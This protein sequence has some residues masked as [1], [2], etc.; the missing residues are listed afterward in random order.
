M[1]RIAVIFAATVT[2]VVLLF[3]YR[4]STHP[5]ALGVAGPQTRLPT[6]SA[7]PGPTTTPT[8]P[9]G[10]TTPGSGTSGTYDGT[11]AD[12]PYGPVQVRITVAGGRITDARTVQV[13]DESRRDVEINDAAVPVLIQETLQAQSARIDTVSGATYTSEGYINSLQSAIDA[14]HR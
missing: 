8:T 1:S 12:T 9:G 3:S 14:A 7:V 6:G 2:V 4:T 11:A 10:T 5:A 13:P